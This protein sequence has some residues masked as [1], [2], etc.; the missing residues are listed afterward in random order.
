MGHNQT[1]T[2]KNTFFPSNVEPL[3]MLYTLYGLYVVQDIDWL[4]LQY[5]FR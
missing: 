4:E 5:G 1:K 3:K 2:K